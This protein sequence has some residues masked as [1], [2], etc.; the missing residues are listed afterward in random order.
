M[1]YEIHYEHLE[2]GGGGVKNISYSFFS[3]NYKG[4]RQLYQRPT[5][6]IIIFHEQLSLVD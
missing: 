3:L 1:Y 5:R 4:T 6:M 2:W